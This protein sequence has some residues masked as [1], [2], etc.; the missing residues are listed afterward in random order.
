M[1]FRYKCKFAV[2]TQKCYQL[3]DLDFLRL[4]TSG[5]SVPF[6]VTV[7]N[8]RSSI[9]LRNGTLQ[10]LSGFN[11]KALLLK[12]EQGDHLAVANPKTLVVKGCLTPVGDNPDMNADSTLHQL[13]VMT[14]TK[15]ILIQVSKLLSVQ[16]R[17][18]LELIP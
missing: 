16:T 15:R 12:Q 5:I 7:S 1:L 11:I 13:E 10:D 14:I 3:T 8:T 17:K 2:G 4:V 6:I 9:D 18:Q